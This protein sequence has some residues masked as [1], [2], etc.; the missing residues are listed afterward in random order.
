MPVA[1]TAR[2]LR[3]L[4]RVQKYIAQENPKAASRMAVEL[5]AGCD[6]LEFFPERGRPGLKPGTRELTTV[7]PYI[8]VYRIKASHRVEILKIWH[9]C[10]NR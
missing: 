1:F 2:A 5:V 4:A 7:W 6:R 9:G 3:D 10:Q 8:I